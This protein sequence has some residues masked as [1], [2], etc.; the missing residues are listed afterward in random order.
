MKLLNNSTFSMNV[1]ILETN[2]SV[3]SGG[4]FVISKRR[5]M[6]KILALLTVAFLISCSSEGR[7]QL[8]LGGSDKKNLFILDTKTGDVFFRKP[9]GWIKLIN[10]VDNPQFIEEL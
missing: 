7:Y 4:I 10:G 1:C 8:E 2:P 3:N 9:K 6:R 5:F